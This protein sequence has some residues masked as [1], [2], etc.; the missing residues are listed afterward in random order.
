MSN[1]ILHGFAWFT[2]PDVLGLEDG[3]SADPGHPFIPRPGPVVV[4]DEVVYFRPIDPDDAGIGNVPRAHS[5][6]VLTKTQHHP[7]VESGWESDPAALS[8]KF[9]T[10]DGKVKMA[11]IV[12][13]HHRHAGDLVECDWKIEEV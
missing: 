7:R 6:L 1:K 11:R 3:E 13:L 8:D 2:Y 5:Y 9:K 10:Q 4:P 12:A